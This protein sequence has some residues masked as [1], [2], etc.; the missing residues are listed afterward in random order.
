MVEH[1]NS[2]EIKAGVPS[3]LADRVSRVPRGGRE[4]LGSF[5][6]DLMAK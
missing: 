6:D 1:G 5:I 3:Q 4:A 2:D